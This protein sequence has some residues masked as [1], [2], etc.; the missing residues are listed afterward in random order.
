MNGKPVPIRIAYIGGGSRGWAHALIKDL[1]MHPGFC[2]EVRLY[3]IDRTMAELNARF[4]NWIQ[5][6]PQAVSKW[7]YRAVAS[8]KTALKGA[9]FVF[10]SIQPGSIETM[11]V[12]LEEPTK[13]G[14]YQSVGDSVGPG[15]C[16][17][18][19]RAIRNYRVIARAI[20][21]H[22]P[23]A[24]VLNFTNPM[25]ICTRTLF[26]VFPDIKAYGCC[27]E[28]FGTQKMLGRVYA[29]MTKEPEPSRREIEVNVLGI[30]HFTWIDRASCRGKDS[31]ALLQEYMTKPRVIRKYTKREVE[32]K[33]RVFID[34]HQVA[35]EL[36][37]RFGVLAAAGDRHLAEFVPWFLTSRDSCF[38]WG[39]CLTPYSYRLQRYRDASKRFRQ[40]MRTGKFPELSWSGEEYLNQMLALTGQGSF[41]TNVNLPNFGQMQN[42]P[43]GAV[44]ETNAVFSKDRVVPVPS[45][46]LPANVNVLVLRHVL[47]QESL[48]KAVFTEDKDLAFQAFLNEPL[49]SLSMDD[50]WKLFNTMLKKTHFEFKSRRRSAH[51]VTSNKEAAG[52]LPSLRTTE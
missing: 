22:A 3:D 15:G 19:L 4:A 8:L 33:K 17:R 51:R 2:G 34:H 52:I 20:A 28:V 35:Y 43:A 41:K 48:V 38:R 10:A 13:Y 39:F 16:L 49:V 5:S 7:K 9:D 18:A 37:R 42:I 40:M 14:I 12:D 47:N 23:Q 26:E 32:T 1:L 31:L 30:N 29:S 21:E 11:K 24:W 6:H 44:V 25:S 46:A 50:A 27:H 36:F 45:G